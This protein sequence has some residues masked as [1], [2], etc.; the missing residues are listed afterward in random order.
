[1]EPDPANQSPLSWLAESLAWE[2]NLRALRARSVD[3]PR[4]QPSAPPQ[5]LPRLHPA[6]RPVPVDRVA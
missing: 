4:Q 6:T 2:A 1:M 3:P 5:T